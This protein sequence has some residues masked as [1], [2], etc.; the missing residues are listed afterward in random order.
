MMNL[1]ATPQMEDFDTCKLEYSHE[2]NVPE[3]RV[4]QRFT[5]VIDEAVFVDSSGSSC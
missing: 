1:R 4:T 5:L 3:R 2:I